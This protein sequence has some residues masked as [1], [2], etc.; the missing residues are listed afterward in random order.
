MS[1][2]HKSFIVEFFNQNRFREKYNSQNVEVDHREKRSAY[3]LAHYA[4]VS[5]LQTQLGFRLSLASSEL[6]GI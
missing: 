2:D 1:S 6:R 3:T 4:S 5:H